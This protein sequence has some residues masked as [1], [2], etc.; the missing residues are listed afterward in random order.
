MPSVVIMTRNPVAQASPASGANAKLAATGPVALGP[1]D[2]L[3]GRDVFGRMC[4]ACH[5]AKGGDVDGHDLRQSRD[6]AAIVAAIKAPKQP[7]PKMFPDVLNEQ[8]VADLAA[9][10][11]D[12]PH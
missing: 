10:V 9:Y 3:R 5:G 6:L 12:L 2:P 8:Q 7:M 4:S 11:H 1:G